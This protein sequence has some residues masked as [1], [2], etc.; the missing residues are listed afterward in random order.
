MFH[1]PG[2]ID[3]PSGGLA[4]NESKCKAHRITRKLTPVTASCQLNEQVLGTS[5]AEKRP[6][7]Q[8]GFVR[9]VQSPTGC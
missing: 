6:L 8:V 9:S 3:A 1:V 4:F 5:T 7:T 2:F